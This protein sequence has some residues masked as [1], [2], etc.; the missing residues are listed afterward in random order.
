MDSFQIISSQQGHAFRKPVDLCSQADSNNLA[1]CSCSLN[2][3]WGAIGQTPMEC[4]PLDYSWFVI[5]LLALDLHSRC[6]SALCIVRFDVKQVEDGR[7]GYKNKGLNERL[8]TAISPLG[9]KHGIKKRI[10]S[11]GLFLNEEQRP[12]Y[13]P[14]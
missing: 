14:K 10:K 11:K 3:E 9:P 4:L 12:Q 6:S 13:K 5:S 1:G 8:K 2:E 7:L